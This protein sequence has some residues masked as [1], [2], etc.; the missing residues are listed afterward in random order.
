MWGGLR[1][2][3]TYRGDVLRL[4]DGSE[5]GRWHVGDMVTSIRPSDSGGVVMSTQHAIQYA[6]RPEADAVE[7]AHPVEDSRQR[8]NDGA[9]DPD[10]AFWCGTIDRG[11]R[12]VGELFRITADGVSSRMLGG[13]SISNGIDFSPDGRLMYYADTATGRIDVFDYTRSRTI[14]GRRPFIRI[15]QGDGAPDGFTVDSEGGLWVAIWDGGALRHYASDGAFVGE[16]RFPV[17]KVTACTFGGAELN[18]LFVTTSRED[19]SFPSPAA[20][21]LFRVRT[22]VRGRAARTFAL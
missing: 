1:W 9:C 18:E 4:I 5:V 6:S 17:A 22:A 10:G 7:I 21:A 8:L 15:A 12:G 2:V 19:E 20:G 13:I 11:G 14:S 16:I 3:D